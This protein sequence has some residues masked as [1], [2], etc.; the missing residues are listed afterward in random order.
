MTVTSMLKFYITKVGLGMVVH[1]FN[2]S[3]WEV[4]AG[5]SLWVWGQPGIHSE[6]QT[7]KGHKVRKTKEGNRK[8]KKKQN[9][10]QYC[11]GNRIFFEKSRI[12]YYQHVLI[13]YCLKS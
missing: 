7:R 8:F 1:F 2:P 10:R 3:I 4:E 9:Y 12:R 11:S 5:I 6:I 13:Q